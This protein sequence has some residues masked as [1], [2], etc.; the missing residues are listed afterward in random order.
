MASDH[1]VDDCCPICGN[2][3]YARLFQVPFPVP[4]ATARRGFPLKEEVDVPTWIIARCQNFS[5]EYVCPRPTV[6]TITDF[7][8]TQLNPN[9]WEQEHY[10]EMHPRSRQEWDRFAAKLTTLCG[11]P[12]SI[13]EIG[14]AAGWLLKAARDR[15]W[16]V[17]GI[18]ASPK[19]Q[20]Y[21]T[22]TLHLPVKLGTIE[23][24]DTTTTNR[25][26]VIVMTD[27]MEHLQDPVAD[28][29]K[30]RAVIASDGFLVLTTCDI[31]SFFARY[32]GLEWR[33]IVLS[34]TI[35]WTKKSMAHALGRA[36]FHVEHLS[37]PRY[38]DPNPEEERRSQVREIAKLGARIALNSSYVP[39]TQRFPVLQQVPALATNNRITHT[40]LMYKIGDQPVLGDVML[41]I[42]RPV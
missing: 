18:E 29:K 42:A 15:G 34:H 4:S 25:Y 28:L 9:D 40:S 35:Y 22:E 10:V 39:L 27:V 5:V 8:A 12:S 36:G 11:A 17:A 32:R 7:Y 24:L 2:T 37:E 31:D 23:D 26:D 20:T 33:Q 6:K 41:V 19:F 16:N 21:A 3:R 13:L 1:V 30:L 14:C 38:W